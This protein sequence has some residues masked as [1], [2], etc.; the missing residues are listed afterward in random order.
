MNDHKERAHA[1]LAPSGAERWV[2][3]PA[4]IRMEQGLPDSVSEAALEGTLAHEWSE[5]IFNAADTLR[6][7]LYRQ[8]ECSEMRFHVQENVE[9]MQALFNSFVAKHNADARLLVETRFHYSEYIWGT[10]DFAVLNDNEACIYDFKYGR[11]HEVGA[12]ENLQLICYA[13]AVRKTLC[14]NPEK[15]HVY[16]FQPRAMS[17]EIFKAWHFDRS[18]LD[19]W[20][21]ELSKAEKVALDILGMDLNEDGLQNW[22]NAGKHCTFCKAK[23]KCKNYMAKN[24][25]PALKIVDNNPFIKLQGNLRL[26]DKL[27]LFHRKKEIEEYANSILDFLSN[28]EHELL[29]NMRQG[30][31]YEG[32]KLIE[33]RGRRSWGDN[34][35]KIAD[36]LLK[37]GKITQPYVTKQ[38]LIGITEAERLLGKS[39]PMKELMD[40]LTVMGE[41][42]LQVVRET[43]PRP[44]IKGSDKLMPTLPDLPE[45]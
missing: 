26:D 39:K 31:V 5:K 25:H 44:E 24:D 30:V 37:T 19:E 45:N 36:E 15:W 7:G 14:I 2:N 11:R 21:R 43:D 6:P 20:E 10:L 23:F 28:I 4:S 17:G 16:I 42:K 9:K 13:L 40:R 12:E 18:V 35:L 27:E 41:G 29:N 34:E 1:L 32:L 33:S 8:I 38:S 22:T 3:C